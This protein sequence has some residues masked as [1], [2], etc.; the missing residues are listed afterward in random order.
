MFFGNIRNH[1][2]HNNNP[3]AVQF[4][5]AYK[6]ILCHLELKSTFTGNSISLENFCIL[7]RSSIRCI[8]ATSLT[9]I[10]EEKLLECTDNAENAL[11]STFENNYF[12]LSELLDRKQE[13]SVSINIIVGYIPGW[14][15]RKLLK[16]IK[17]EQ[18]LESMLS[19]KKNYFHQLIVV[20]DMGGLC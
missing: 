16:K 13:L 8:N 1:G 9:N 14:V 5:A 2:G 15:V 18:C 6:K 17:C 4:M 19:K 20:K 10:N 11:D 3:T 7:S 12:I